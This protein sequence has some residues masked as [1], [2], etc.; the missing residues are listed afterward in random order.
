MITLI[1]RL[2]AIKNYAKDIHYHAHGDSFYGIH[3]LM[4]RVSDGIDEQID[5]IKEVCYLGAIQEVPSSADIL[6]VASAY[7]PEITDDNKENIGRLSDLIAQTLDDV[8]RLKGTS[9]AQDSVLDTVA[10]SLQL[11]RGLLWRQK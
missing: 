9:P 1:E 11:K 5:T 10:Q 6:K 4:D 8:E 2:E 7:I 3:L